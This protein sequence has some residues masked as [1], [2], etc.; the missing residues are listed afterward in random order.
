MPA[1][2]K[3]P[4]SRNYTEDSEVVTENSGKFADGNEGGGSDEEV[5]EEDE[6]EEKTRRINNFLVGIPRPTN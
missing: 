5:G 1:L 4:C 3:L 6:A 2:G